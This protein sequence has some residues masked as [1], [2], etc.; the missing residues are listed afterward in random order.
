M[1][2]DS[3]HGTTLTFE[4]GFHAMITN[5]SHSGVTRAA[6]P[7]SHS[8]TS[9]GMTFIPADLIDSGE[10]NVDILFDLAAAPPVDQAA[11]TCTITLPNG[12]TIAGSAF[13]TSFRFTIPTA[14]DEGIMTANT[15]LKYSGNIT[16][17][18]PT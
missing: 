6:L 4:S 10:L 13:M 5:I 1:A 9:G 2:A 12:G 15:T 8:S 18:P 3:G 17:T 7:T 16:W 11:E 14:Q